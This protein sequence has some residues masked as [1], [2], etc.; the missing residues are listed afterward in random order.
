MPRIYTPPVITLVAHHVTGGYRADVILIAE[1]VCPPARTVDE[2]STI[3]ITVVRTEPV[4]TAGDG[5]DG[6][7]PFPV[8]Y[9]A[10]IAGARFT[11]GIPPT[12]CVLHRRGRC[13]LFP[14]DP[15]Q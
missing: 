2:D 4:P 8:D 1:Y 9:S 7:E 5:V 15:S 3:P 10:I 12:R 13:Y 6:Y 11:G 14:G